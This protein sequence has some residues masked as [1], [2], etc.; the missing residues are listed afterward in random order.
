MFDKNEPNYKVIKYSEFVDPGVSENCRLKDVPFVDMNVGL[1]LSHLSAE[2]TEDEAWKLGGCYKINDKRYRDDQIWE[3]YI[4]AEKYYVVKFEMPDPSG[5]LFGAWGSWHP[6]RVVLY[7]S[8]KEPLSVHVEKQGADHIRVT[9]CY[10]AESMIRYLTVWGM[11]DSFYKDE[12]LKC[13]EDLKHCY[14]ELI[15]IRNRILNLYQKREA[16][17]NRNGI[18]FYTIENDTSFES[19]LERNEE[20]SLK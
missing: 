7:D 15:E 20:L 2:L 13:N 6:F 12:I 5:G 9:D 18:L 16:I 10:T 8:N 4:G 1:K 11:I 14:K 17:K 19:F 3:L